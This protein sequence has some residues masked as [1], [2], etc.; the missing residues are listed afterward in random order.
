MVT[1]LCFLGIFF[2]HY[3]LNNLVFFSHLF[4]MP[5]LLFII[6]P[7]IVGSIN[8]SLIQTHTFMDQAIPF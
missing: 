7:Y 8:F 1:K 3:L 4:V 5:P 6:F 2:L